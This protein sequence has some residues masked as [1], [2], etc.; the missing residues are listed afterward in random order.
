MQTQAAS[1]SGVIDRPA[2]S[3]RQQPVANTASGQRGAP[4]GRWQIQAVED[5][6]S[7]KKGFDAFMRQHTNDGRQDGEVDVTATCDPVLLNFNIVFLSDEKPGVLLN[8]VPVANVRRGWSITSRLRINDDQVTTVTSREEFANYIDITFRSRTPPKGPLLGDDR[9]YRGPESMFSVGDLPA[10]LGARSITVELTTEND[11][12][13][14]IELKPQDPEFQKFGSRCGNEFWG[15][16]P[17]VAPPPPKAPAT[18]PAA[19]APP[20]KAPVTALMLRNASAGPAEK[21]AARTYRGNLDGFIAALPGYLQ[22]AAAGIGAPSRSYD[23]EIGYIAHAARQCAGITSEQAASVTFHNVVDVSRLGEA[24][25]DCAAPYG[26]PVPKQAGPPDRSHPP[27][28]G[29]LM[30]PIRLWGDGN[31]ISITASFT[32]VGFPG[33]RSGDRQTCAQ[34]LDCGIAIGLIEGGRAVQTQPK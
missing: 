5:K 20:P 24:Y 10:A 29:V 13:H 30:R 21:R 2:G 6:L 25:R 16:G 3:A 27:E 32:E 19:A 17:A 26:V 22:R 14:I 4:Q 8:A 7:G 33:T 18:A 12:R 15:G 28:L 11:V 9:Y 1:K 34:G 31:G 23:Y